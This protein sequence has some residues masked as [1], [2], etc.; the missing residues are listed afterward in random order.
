MAFIRKYKVVCENQKPIAGG[1]D[2][3]EGGLFILCFSCG[4][5]NHA[6]ADKCSRCHKPMLPSRNNS[7][8]IIGFLIAVKGLGLAFF[9]QQQ[10][11]LLLLISLIGIPMLMIAGGASLAFS[12]ETLEKRYRKRAGIHKNVCPDQAIL[13]L[14]KAYQHARTAEIKLEILAERAEIYS[15]IGETHHE[16]VESYHC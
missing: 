11:N 1:L 15:K 8:R 12:R 5:K 4:K 6:L 13:D 2:R 9:L 10:P 14:T 3:M 7:T 16:K